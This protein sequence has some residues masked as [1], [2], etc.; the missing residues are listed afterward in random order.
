MCIYSLSLGIFLFKPL[1]GITVS[2]STISSAHMNPTTY[3]TDRLCVYTFKCHRRALGNVFLRIVS[4]DRYFEFSLCSLIRPL[5]PLVELYHTPF[6]PPLFGYICIL[7]I[8]FINPQFY[9]VHHRIL[10]LIPLCFFF[11]FFYSFR[12]Y[13]HV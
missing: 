3:Y 10:L 4:L 12:A 8:V 11:F 9:L 6:V 2:S 5:S 13:I 1:C 7:A